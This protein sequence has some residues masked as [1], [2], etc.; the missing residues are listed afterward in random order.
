MRKLYEYIQQAQAFGKV[1]IEY[2]ALDYREFKADDMGDGEESFL[3][4]L[5][6]DSGQVFNDSKLQNLSQD[7]IVMR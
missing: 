2:G 7:S 5:P 4:L 3:N 6:L 1:A